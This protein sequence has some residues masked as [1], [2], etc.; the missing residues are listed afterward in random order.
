M[1]HVLLSVLDM[2]RKSYMFTRSMYNTFGREVI[3]I[4][5][6]YEEIPKM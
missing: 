5:R 6:T 4:N 3:D 1:V 2:L